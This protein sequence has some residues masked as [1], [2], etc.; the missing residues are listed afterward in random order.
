MALAIKEGAAT[1]I[2]M[3][4]LLFPDETYAQAKAAVMK[5]TKFNNKLAKLLAQAEKIKAQE[6]ARATKDKVKKK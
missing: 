6:L 2:D 4:M 1:P 3:R 5:S